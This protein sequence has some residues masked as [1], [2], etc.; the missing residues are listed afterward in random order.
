[1]N[2]KKTIGQQ[3]EFYRTQLDWTQTQAAGETGFIVTQQQVGKLENGSTKNPTYHTLSTLLKAYGKRV[4][5]LEDDIEDGVTFAKPNTDLFN[6]G[7]TI[8][9]IENKD[10]VD[11]L[12]GQ[13]VPVIELIPVNVSTGTKSYAIKMTN[14]LMESADRVSYPKNSIVIFDG[15][16]AYSD[17][18]D[19][20]INISGKTIFRNV[21]KD[22]DTYYLKTLNP[23]FPNSGATDKLSYL[24]RAIECRITIK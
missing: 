16:K 23:H 21:F 18:K 9:L 22:G 12:N 13:T 6:Y 20:M 7:A 10:V 15:S 11:F 4:S 24:G 3:L 5:D 8:P 19:M 14:E 2:M 17:H 1:M